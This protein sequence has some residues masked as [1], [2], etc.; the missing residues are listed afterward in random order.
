MGMILT[1]LNYELEGKLAWFIIS[2]DMMKKVNASKSDI[3]GFSDMVRSI[4]GVEVAIMISEQSD[5]NCRI[6]FRSKGNL[7]IN[8]IANMLGGGGHAYASGAMVKGSLSSVQKKV[9]N[10]SVSILKKD[11]ASLAQ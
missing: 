10:S 6:N 3:D 4:R 8:H 7:K 1:D 9:V 11:I 5:N 2:R